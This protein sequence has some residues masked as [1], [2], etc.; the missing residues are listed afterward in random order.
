[1]K[2]HGI[3]YCTLERKLEAIR[4]RGWNMTAPKPL[5]DRQPQAFFFFHIIFIF[6]YLTFTAVRSDSSRGTGLKLR[7][8]IDAAEMIRGGHCS[9]D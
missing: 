8:S 4:N 7:Y 3:D 6:I 1:M 2:L 5:P 9:Q